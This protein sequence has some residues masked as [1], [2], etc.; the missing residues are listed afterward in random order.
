MIGLRSAATNMASRVMTCIVQEERGIDPPL[1]K[2]KLSSAQQ[3]SLQLF[4]EAV[5][6]AG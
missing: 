3:R 5:P 4:G 6:I 1:S 2:N